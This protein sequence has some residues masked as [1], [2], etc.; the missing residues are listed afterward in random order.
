[1]RARSKDCLI[2]YIP[3]ALL[4]P[5]YPLRGAWRPITKTVIWHL[6]NRGFFKEKREQQ[7]ILLANLREIFGPGWDPIMSDITNPTRKKPDQSEDDGQK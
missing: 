3:N 1:M 7:E 5:E 2:D 6:N 4:F